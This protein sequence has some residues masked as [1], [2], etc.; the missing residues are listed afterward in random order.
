MA[1]N[2]EDITTKVAKARYKDWQ[3]KRYHE[4]GAVDNPDAFV[5]LDH[6][7]HS[8][9]LP[10]AL[11]QQFAQIGR[12]QGVDPY[13]FT[14]AAISES[15]LGRARPENP[16]SVDLGQH[17]SHG[18]TFVDRIQETGQRPHP[19]ELT[20]Y[21]ASYMKEMLSKFSGNQLAGIQAYSGTGEKT[22]EKMPGSK[23]F[24]KELSSTHFWRDKDHAKRVKSI[25]DA[26]RS[27]K[28]AREVI[29][30]AAKYGD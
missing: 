16:L 13:I 21:A 3:D 6:P 27:N 5:W 24:G 30:Q 22:T 12:E 18:E 8:D 9:Y 26:L 19:A 2:D 14:G 28:D 20:D 1:D 7:T 10:K 29:D 23:I 11:L 15:N 17:P 4:S 25:A